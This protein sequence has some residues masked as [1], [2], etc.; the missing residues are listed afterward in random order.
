MKG[1]NLVAKPIFYSSAG[2]NWGWINHYGPGI[3]CRP[4][5][6]VPEQCISVI[7]DEDEGVG[8]VKKGYEPIDI[9]PCE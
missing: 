2:S 4:H 7:K 6:I 5:L 8:L 3:F 1:E 9:I